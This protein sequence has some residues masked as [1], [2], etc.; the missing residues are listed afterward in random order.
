[1]LA[2]NSPRSGEESPTETLTPDNPRRQIS[3]KYDEILTISLVTA[4][5]SEDGV[6]RMLI[7]AEWEAP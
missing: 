6:G 5:G 4:S 2:F 3:D 7:L 1:M